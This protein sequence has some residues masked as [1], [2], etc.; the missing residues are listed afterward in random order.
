MVA[1]H[2]EHQLTD[3][4]VNVVTRDVLPPHVVLI[5]G[6]VR[7]TNARQVVTLKAEPL[8]GGGFNGGRY[9]SG[10]NTLIV[11]KTRLDDD[12]AGCSV[13]I[14]NYGVA[15]AD[16]VSARSSRSRTYVNIVSHDADDTKRS[17]RSRRWSMITSD[18]G[19]SPGTPGSSWPV[20]LHRAHWTSPAYVE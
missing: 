9:D 11:W 15:M 17:A 20:T 5:P 12:F 2:E 3:A 14:A 10:D 4:F 13:R 16:G 6:S 18:A 8:F 1:R 19:R 7:F